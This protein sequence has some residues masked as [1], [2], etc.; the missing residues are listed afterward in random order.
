[1]S[2]CRSAVP[3]SFLRL[4]LFR[5]RRSRRSCTSCRE[6]REGP[7]PGAQEIFVAVFHHVGHAEER[8]VPLDAHGES[9]MAGRAGI[10]VGFVGQHIAHVRLVR[11][12]GQQV[13]VSTRGA[14]VGPAELVAGIEIEVVAFLGKSARGLAVEVRADVVIELAVEEDRAPGRG[15][16]VRGGGVLDKPMQNRQAGVGEGGV[17]NDG[18]EVL[19]AAGR[20]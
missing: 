3:S 9:K 2:A 19:R 10:A 12:G 18:A 6:R 4:L 7:G 16:G 1:M 13:Q 11:P 5:A 8:A 14:S 17:E 20:L 15:I